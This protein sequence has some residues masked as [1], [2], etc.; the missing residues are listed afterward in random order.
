MTPD[1]A[2]IHSIHRDSAWFTALLALIAAKRFA[3]PWQVWGGLL[4]GAG[5][6]LLVL[7]SFELAVTWATAPERAALPARQRSTRV[8]IVAL[9]QAPALA[10]LMYV[11]V[12][13]LEMDGPAIA[14]GVSV[15]MLV[16]LLKALGR[17][18]GRWAASYRDGGGPDSDSGE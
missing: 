1:R 14:A 17:A 16:G 4:A 7:A 15:P 5:L 12:T 10:G 3:C 18:W 9:G 2:R 13:R 8:M 6:A 11:F